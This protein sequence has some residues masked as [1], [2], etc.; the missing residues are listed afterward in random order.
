V[1]SPERAYAVAKYFWREKPQHA[2]TQGFFTHG[3]ILFESDFHT[4]IYLPLLAVLTQTV[5]RTSV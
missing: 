1:L 2:D 3:S 4:E 5:R